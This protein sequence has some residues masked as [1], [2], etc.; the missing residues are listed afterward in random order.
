[1]MI[2]LKNLTNTEN[3]KR[4]LSNFLSL[5]VLQCANYV[6]PLITLPYLVRVLGAEY[7][8]LLSFAT[9]T[10]SYFGIITDY[11]FNLTATRDI[12]IH[13]DNLEKIKEIFSAVMT[14]KVILMVLS[15][16]TFSIIIFSFDKFSI[17]WKIY[18]ITFGTII[19]QLLFPVW[20]F[21]GMERMKYITYLNILA[22]LIFTVAIFVFVRE[23]NDYYLVPILTSLGFIVAGMWSLWLVKK[24]FNVVFEWQ[25]QQVLKRHLLQGSHMFLTSIQSNILS[26]SGVFVLG[27]FQ[28]NEIVGL[29]SAVEKLAKAFVGLFAPVTQAL[30][31]LVSAK[32][33]HSKIEGKFFLVKAAQII[34]SLALLVSI[35]MTLFSSKIVVLVLGVKFL[36]Y[37]YIL[38][39][40][41]VWL[42][43]GVLNNFIGIQYLTGIGCSKFY[44]KSSF[45]SGL[46]ALVLFFSLTP[47]ISIYGILA[48]MVVAEIAFTAIMIYS[49]RSY[50][51]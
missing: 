9:A 6:L 18:F 26:S 41:S 51:L 17:D 50:G 1:M 40:L 13:R 24:E 30:F 48:G 35:G 38:K 36:E 37:G 25:S 46:I 23:K 27:L 44:L 49:I 4:L 45:I 32:L 39:I 8:G 34:L 7:F 3:K 28:Q 21:Q 22:K 29:Y 20:F 31:P 47:Y 33:S 43:F 12:S 42:F 16:V 14:I 10:V 19:G 11:G 15:V 2:K 5:S